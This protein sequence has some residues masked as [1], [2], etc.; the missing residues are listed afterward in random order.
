MGPKRSQ[1]KSTPPSVVVDNS[2]SLENT[3]P[4]RRS[5][6]GSIRE[7]ILLTESSSHTGSS[8]INPTDEGYD[9]VFEARR[10]R[11]ANEAAAAA[12]SPSL[13][14]SLSNSNQTASLNQ[15]VTTDN[16]MEEL[17]ANPAV[18]LHH[19]TDTVD[20]WTQNAKSSFAKTVR[21]NLLH[22]ALQI[23]FNGN[24]DTNVIDFTDFNLTTS[25]IIQVMEPYI[26]H[27]SQ[28]HKEDTEPLQLMTGMK[29][30]TGFFTK[31]DVKEFQQFSHK[32]SNK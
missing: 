15:N 16:Q 32:I 20:E 21:N 19:N 25:E 5:S 27:P 23:L 9:E 29:V 13:D 4:N 2:T 14:S 26:T 10:L 18:V 7:P 17:E 12:P 11:D 1:S 3:R 31:Q 22:K 6:G 8:F 30:L 24:L 28:S